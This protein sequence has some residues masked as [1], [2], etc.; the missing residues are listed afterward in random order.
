[1]I[2]SKESYKFDLEAKGLTV[3]YTSFMLSKI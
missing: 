2:D 3:F 1:M